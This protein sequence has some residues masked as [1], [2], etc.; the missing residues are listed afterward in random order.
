MKEYTCNCCD[1]KWQDKYHYNR[2]LNAK[3]ITGEERKQ[4]KT[5][6]DKKIYACGLCGKTFRDN[7][8]LGKHT[9]FKSKNTVAV[10]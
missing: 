4:H 7:W 5:R 10:I 2:H 3:K 6:C 1:K 9:S 8:F